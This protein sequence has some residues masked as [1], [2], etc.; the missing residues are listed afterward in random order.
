MDKMN[1]YADE[2]RFVD[3][4][5]SDSQRPLGGKAYSAPAVSEARKPGRAD[6]L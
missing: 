5:L 3:A 1:D 4:N 2:G 6:K